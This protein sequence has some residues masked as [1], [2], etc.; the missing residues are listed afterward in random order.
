MGNISLQTHILH[1]NNWWGFHWIQNEQW[2]DDEKK[3]ITTTTSTSAASKW[4]AILPS[5]VKLKEK[6]YSFYNDSESWARF[7]I[8]EQNNKRKKNDAG[9]TSAEIWMKNAAFA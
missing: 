7:R 4:N 5:T 3:T 1:T 6:K 8:G 2:N 9:E